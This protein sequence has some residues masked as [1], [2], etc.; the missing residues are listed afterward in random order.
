MERENFEGK[1]GS[2]QYRVEGGVSQRSYRGKLKGGGGG[3]DGWC[4]LQ[5]SGGKTNSNIAY[6]QGVVN[7]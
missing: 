5:Y 6:S 4:I 2:E 7:P 1:M 3:S